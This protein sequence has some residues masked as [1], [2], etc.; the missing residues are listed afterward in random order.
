VHSELRAA[1]SAVVHGPALVAAATVAAESHGGWQRGRARR[2]AVRWVS[3]GGT[4]PSRARGGAEPGGRNQLPDPRVKRDPDA[5][6]AAAVRGLSRVMAAAAARTEMEARMSARSSVMSLWS[7]ATMA[8][9]MIWGRRRVARWFSSDREG[10]LGRKSCKSRRGSGFY[11]ETDELLSNQA[12]KKI[13]GE[14]RGFEALILIIKTREDPNVKSTIKR[15]KN[16]DL[17]TAFTHEEGL[18]F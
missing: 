2:S 7:S 17:D 1:H 4:R 10:T 14:N 9:S 15:D 18:I 3:S 11:A 6:I 13:G 8:A 12:R 16:T 5:V